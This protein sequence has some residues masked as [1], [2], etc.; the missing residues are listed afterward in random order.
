MVLL[1]VVYF[2]GRKMQSQQV[3]NQKM[4]EASTQTVTLLVIDKKKM[5]LKF[6]ILIMTLGILL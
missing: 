5:K 1:I 2:V 4:I 3:E 6:L